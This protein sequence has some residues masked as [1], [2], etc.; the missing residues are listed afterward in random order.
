MKRKKIAVVTPFFPNSEQ[1][2]WG[3]STYQLARKLTEFADIHVVCLLP[4]YP[5]WLRPRSFGY[6][7]PNRDFKLPDLDVSYLSFPAIPYLSRAVNGTVCEHYLL[8]RIRSLSP[9]LILNY[10]LYPQ[11]YAAVE[12]G[13]KLGIPVVVGSIGTDLNRLEDP[14]VRWL[15]RLTLNRA[16][17]VV[18][19]SRSLQE[20]AIQLGTDPSRV[21]TIGN[22]CD[23][24][25][26]HLSDRNEAREKLNLEKTDPLIIYVGRI[27]SRKGISELIEAF[28]VVA[29]NG[30]RDLRVS[31]IGDG[32]TSYRTA[33]SE[34]IQEL[35]LADRVMFIPPITPGE[36]SLWLAAANILVLP[37]YAE[38]CP[39]VVL[40]AISC[41][42]PVVATAVG[43]VP[44][45]VNEQCSVLVPPR[46]VK[47]L[48]TGIDVALNRSWDESSIANH[49]QRSWQQVARETYDLCLSALCVKDRCKNGGNTSRTARHDL[50]SGPGAEFRKK[51]RAFVIGTLLDSDAES[52]LRILLS[53]FSSVTS[54]DRPVRVVIF[55]PCNLHESFLEKVGIEDKLAIE[56]VAEH[57]RFE[58]SIKSLD[59][60]LSL[61]EG[62]SPLALQAM[63]SGVPLITTASRTP[64]VVKNLQT[65]IVIR[66]ADTKSLQAALLQIADNRERSL[67]I[68]AKAERGVKQQYSMTY[69]WRTSSFGPTYESESPRRRF[70]KQRLYQAISQ[71]LLFQNGNRHR[72]EIAL[73]IDDGPDP[74]YTPQILDILRDRGIRATFFVVGGCVEQYGDIIAR[75]V[76]EGH[77]VGNH[78][79][80]HPY[81]NKLSWRAAVNEIRMTSAVLNR[82]L[83]KR[84]RFFRPP[85]G[86]LCLHSLLP[87]WVAGHEVAMFNVDLK[88]YRA[89]AAELDEKV[90]RTHFSSGDIILYHGVTEAALRSLPRVIEAAVAQGLTPSTVSELVRP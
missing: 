18:T 88:D 51:P 27:E 16:T 82:I 81:F 23:T 43:G 72:A 84:S 36:V 90:K 33:L 60:L 65:A 87:A 42:R 6:R 41:G 80:S 35:G 70:A 62:T 29:R 83:K 71:R 44:E 69:L 64:E 66:R 37:S 52:N 48:A 12:V 15:T 7:E 30:R 40:E 38:G 14:I 73:T 55:G 28:A 61:S 49:F 89:S 57:P 20:R 34:R 24:S 54:P 45:M 47:A 13:R 78:S 5:K 17:L 58:A 50:P 67:R 46:D 31:I 21:H 11:G 63:A 75:M 59:V 4:R 53:T 9:D 79:Y 10:W 56:M 26:F 19:K 3:T 32:G 85:F 2:F 74:V 25:I 68:S 1:P 39:N 8:E 77:E 76:D 22:G 86:K